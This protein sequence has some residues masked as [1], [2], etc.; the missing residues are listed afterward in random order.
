MTVSTRNTFIAGAGA[1]ALITLGSMAY[2]GG[3]MGGPGKG[4]MGGPD[5]G[6][7]PCCGKGPKGHNVVVPGVNVSGPNVTVNQGNFTLNKGNIVINNRSIVRNNQTIG[8]ET[9]IFGGGGG[10]FFPT[11]GV[12]P[13]SIG[14]LNLQGNVIE[15]ITENVATTEEFCE[16]Q[17]SVQTVRRP[18]QAVCIDDKGAPHPAS[19]VIGTEK[20]SSHYHGEVFRCMAGTSMQVTLGKVDHGKASFAHGETFSCNKG[21]ALV[22]SAGGN[23]SCKVQIP[24]RSCNE[25]SLLRRHG[26]GIKLIE[27]QLKTK[28]CVPKTRTV[29]KPV[30]RQVERLGQIKGEA[31]VFDGGVGQ[32]V[33]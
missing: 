24:Q 23:L 5:K 13:S 29:M 16:E 27:G 32:G 9:I 21:E 22:H 19:Q 11:P 26:P 3:P 15:T 12:S 33:N 17:I 2:A 6:G 28:T 31:I 25:R 14:A 30:Q 7:S 10:G 8:G 18:V 20:I 4:P 1:L